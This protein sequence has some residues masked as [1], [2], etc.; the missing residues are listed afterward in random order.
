[1]SHI[2]EADIRLSYLTYIPEEASFYLAKEIGT[3]VH[4]V[5]KN[6]PSWFF[7]F[8][9]VFALT[10]CG[11]RLKVDY[12]LLEILCEKKT[13]DNLILNDVSLESFEDGASQV[14]PLIKHVNVY[15]SLNF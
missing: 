11:D 4:T 7:Q 5:Y 15:R 10:E 6:C 1:M 14:K 2:L 9:Y 8:D 3:V 12:G 13:L